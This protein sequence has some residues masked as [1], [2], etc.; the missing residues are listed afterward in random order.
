M[1]ISPKNSIESIRT[2][3]S[4]VKF[5]TEECN[6]FPLKSI[7][8]KCETILE[9]GFKIQAVVRVT[10]Y[11]CTCEDYY[12]YGVQHGARHHYEALSCVRKI[13]I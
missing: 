11:S 5:C 1:N 13:N 12:H 10:I 2:Q 9:E 6:L 3:Y 4:N 7:T 8:S